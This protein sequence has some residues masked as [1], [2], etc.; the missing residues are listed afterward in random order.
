MQSND[1]IPPIH[2]MRHLLEM[3]TFFYLLPWGVH[4]K[5]VRVRDKEKFLYIN[6]EVIIPTNADR[7]K[8]LLYLH[9]GGYTI[10][11]SHSHRSFVGKIVQKAGIVGF[12]VDYRK[13][14][15]NPFP[16]ALEDALASYKSLLDRGKKAENILIGGDSA[17][18]GLAVALLLA[19]RD[20][21]LPYP[22]AVIALSPWMDLAVTGNTIDR[23][24]PEDP[25]VDRQKMERWAKMYAGDH[26]L[27]DPY[28][29]PLYADLTGFPPILLQSSDSEML[30]DDA[31]RFA[32]KGRESGVEITLQV[33]KGL[34]HWW[35][36]FQRVIPEA[37]EALDEI[38]LYIDLLFKSRKM[39]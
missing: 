22:G 38:V 39:N 11:S 33:W 37:G 36:L 3:G 16:A 7:D 27:K 4:Y 12:L 6:A 2:H 8:V 9:G 25:L 17:G 30:H 18:G 34:I 10:G 1:S 31:L 32:K 19:I 20:A 21:G 35:H 23:N 24:E 15:E 29:S 5:K 28:V 13:A 14:P 26:D